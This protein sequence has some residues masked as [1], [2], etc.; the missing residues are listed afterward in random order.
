MWIEFL[1][2]EYIVKEHSNAGEQTVS[3]C[4]YSLV[5]ACE[6]GVL[7]SKKESYIASNIENACESHPPEDA[8]L[9]MPISMIVYSDKV[10][11]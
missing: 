2:K 3:S 10:L 4:G 9:Q 7:P 5:D 8:P 1:L 11:V 6:E